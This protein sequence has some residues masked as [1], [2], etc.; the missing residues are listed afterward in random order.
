M[1]TTF[2]AL[3]EVLH[4]QPNICLPDLPTSFFKDLQHRKGDA[5]DYKQRLPLEFHKFIYTV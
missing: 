4:T 5:D 1:S 2:G 3:E